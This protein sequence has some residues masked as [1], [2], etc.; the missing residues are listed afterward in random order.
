[1]ETVLRIIHLLGEK[2]CMCG[3]RF[4]PKSPL[5]HFTEKSVTKL[6]DKN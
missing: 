3:Q 4:S 6:C 1:M 2:A 5:K